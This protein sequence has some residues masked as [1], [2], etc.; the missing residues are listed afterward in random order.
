MKGYLKQF[1][2]ESEKNKKEF[3]KETGSNKID[4]LKK[5]VESDMNK[6]NLLIIALIC[7]CLFSH[8]LISLCNVLR[9]LNNEFIKVI[10]CNVQ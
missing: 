8:L 5:K 4:N 10:K 2:G 1:G 9:N 6:M 7:S 3:E